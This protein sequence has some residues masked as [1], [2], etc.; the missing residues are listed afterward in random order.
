MKK[1]VTKT[2]FVGVLVD[3]AMEQDKADT[4]D[5]GMLKIQEREAFELMANTVIDNFWSVPEDQREIVMLA[6]L[7]KL[8]VENFV[9]NARL[10]GAES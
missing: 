9:L 5:F 3:L 7:T 2:E 10:Q 8:L 1:T 6:S 4:I